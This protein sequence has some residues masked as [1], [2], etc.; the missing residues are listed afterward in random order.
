[1]A[2][3]RRAFESGPATAYD[4]LKSSR[5]ALRDRRPLPDA[6]ALSQLLARLRYLERL[7]ALIS[8]ET[9]DGIRYALAA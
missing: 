6:Y 5:H 4:L 7:G 9:P 3:I 1:L 8:S 2:Q